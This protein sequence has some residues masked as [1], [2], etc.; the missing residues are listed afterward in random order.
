MIGFVYQFDNTALF[1]E[2]LINSYLEQQHHLNA[3]GE[4]IKCSTV[5][6]FPSQKREK[7]IKYQECVDL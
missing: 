7:M 5:F 6:N 3:Y 4:V 2:T 1:K